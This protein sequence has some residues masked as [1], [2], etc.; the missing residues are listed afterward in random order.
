M[1]K[2]IEQEIKHKMNSI[3]KYKVKL[4]HQYNKVMWNF[5]KTIHLIVINYYFHLEKVII[6]IIDC[7]C[8]PKSN[9]DVQQ[10]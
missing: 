1:L 9:I 10:P 5:I 7:L 2:K 3:N 4:N 6:Q 8:F